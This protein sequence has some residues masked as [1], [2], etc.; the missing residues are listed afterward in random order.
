M[1]LLF[2]L[3]PIFN[4]II[5]LSFAA[6]QTTV[7]WPEKGYLFWITNASPGDVIN[8]TIKI[9]NKDND[10]DNYYFRIR[11]ITDEHALSHVLHVR[12]SQLSKTLYTGTMND[13][14]SE[15][16]GILLDQ[17]HRNQDNLDLSV[18][19][20]RNAGNLYQK[21]LLSFIAEIGTQQKTHKKH[22][23]IREMCTRY[24]KEVEN[25]LRKVSD[26]PR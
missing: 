3:F 6:E 9:Q 21:S 7:R 5:P 11:I 13:L 15:S 19:F 25:N 10:A 24:I 22:E 16:R 23:S 14:A 4:I 17:L 18:T 26:R 8:R 1:L 2:V 12:I 20:D